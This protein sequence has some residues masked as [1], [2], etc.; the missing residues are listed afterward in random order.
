MLDLDADNSTS[1]GSGYATTFAEDGAAV[2]IA[3]TDIAITASTLRSATITLTN[4]LP[5]DLLSVSG[6]LPGGIAAVY[7]P[8]TGVMRLTGAAPAAAY[9]AASDQIVYSNSS[10]NPSTDNRIITVVVNDGI[11]DS[12]TATAVVNV[13][14][15]NDAPVAQDGS[16]SGSEDTPISGTLV[17]TDVD[18]PSLTYTLGAQ[19]VHGNVVVNADGSYTYTPNLDFNGT[20]SFSFK[21]NDGALDSNV[22]TVSLTVSPVNDAPVAASGSASGNEDT[23]INGTVSAT[24]VDNTSA[25]LSYDLVGTNGGAAH[26]SVV[27]HA[28]GTFTYTPA[29]NFNGSDSFSFKA[30]DGALDSN[31]ATESLTINA[32]NDAPVNTVPGPL[33]AQNGLDAAIIGLAVSDVDAVSLTTSLHVDHGTLSV[34]AVGG[35]TVIGSGTGT[36]TLSGSVAQIDAALG[37][38]NNVLYHPAFN[39]VGTDRLTMTS[40]DGGGTGSGGPQTDTDVVDINAGHGIGAFIAFSVLGSADFHLH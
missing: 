28:D 16:A 31:V 14:A 22:A 7:D 2:T 6:T 12:N 23:A 35:A 17:A 10:H 34:A 38:Q 29:S 36:V 18:S 20:D 24:D 5:G 13:V 26:G 4:P 1:S 15:V 39:F 19:A 27:V 33:N 32:V 21:A 9:Q 3:D 11:N 25:P 30:N 40:N 8:A 37:A